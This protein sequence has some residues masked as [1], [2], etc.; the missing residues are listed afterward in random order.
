MEEK[1][2]TINMPNI[3][4]RYDLEKN[5]DTPEVFDE[6]LAEKIREQLHKSEEPKTEDIENVLEEIKS[7]EVLEDKPVKSER[8]LFEER[9]REKNKRENRLRNKRGRKMRKEQMKKA[10]GK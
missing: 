8:E 2:T 10:K 1:D 5:K 7:E 9:I 6:E 4:D 3:D